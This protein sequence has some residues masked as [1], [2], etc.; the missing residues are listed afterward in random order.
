MWKASAIRWVGRAAL[1]LLGAVIGAIWWDYTDRP[2][3]P[4][5]E[6]L[7]IKWYSGFIARGT[8]VTARVYV[9]RQFSDAQSMATPTFLQNKIELMRNGSQSVFFW[10]DDKSYAGTWCEVLDLNNDGVKEF[11]IG[12]TR[13]T[14]IVWYSDG[15]LRFRPEMD[16]IL[17][18]D[19]D[20]GPF[21]LDSDNRY[22]FVVDQ[23]LETFPHQYRATVP[24]I[25]RWTYKKGFVD[26]SG[27]FKSYY[28]NRVIPDLRSKIAAEKDDGLRSEYEEA[29]RE[30][31]A[32]ISE[33]PQK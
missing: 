13:T 10:P 11:M 2:K 28:K 3:P 17:S 5:P 27:K 21:D 15:T 24:R 1:V 22:E 8:E 30:V 6:W 14:R 19:Y 12:G 31:T 18:L 29:L 33:Q 7:L 4:K 23:P 25:K 20:I 9:A 32:L 16:D 26:V